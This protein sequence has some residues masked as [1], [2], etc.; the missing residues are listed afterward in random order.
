MPH[1]RP[2]GESGPTRAAAPPA[3]TGGRPATT[4][5]EDAIVDVVPYEHTAPDITPCDRHGLRTPRKRHDR[6]SPR[7]GECDVRG[8]ILPLAGHD[9]VLKRGTSVRMFERRCN[10][11]PE[12]GVVTPPEL[13]TQVHNHVAA[14]HIAKD[15]RPGK[16]HWNLPKHVFDIYPAYDNPSVLT[17]CLTQE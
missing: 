10:Q 9:C 16:V 6:P 17:V 5:N 14:N 2:A 4:L 11:P 15:G 8:G 1:V 3:D 7:R 12:P 13:Q